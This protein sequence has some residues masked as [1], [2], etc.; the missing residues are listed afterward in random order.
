MDPR[1]ERLQ[2]ATR[3]LFLHDSAL[4]LGAMALGSLCA[5]RAAAD[6]ERPLATKAGAHPARAKHVIFV[7]LA[8]APPQLD[9]FD[10]KPKLN[11]LHGT[12]CPEEFIA[13]KRLAFIKGHP[14]LLGNQQGFVR[15]GQT[16]QWVSELLPCFGPLVDKVA[17]VRSMHTDQFNHAPADLFLHTGNAQFGAASIGSWLTWGLGSPNQNLPG[18]VVLVTGGSDPT[19][20][21][22][23]WGSGFLPSAYQGVR[24]RS[25]GEPLRQRSQGHGSGRAQAQPRRV[26]HVEREPA[27]PGRRP[28]DPRAHRSVRARL[29]HAALRARGDGPA[30]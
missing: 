11:A 28:G 9:L 1:D 4:G 20:G 19:G 16:G 6:Q 25:Q 23:T 8:G 22:S 14:T 17:M 12:L 26:A 30:P 2:R 15:R 13:G 29:P 10:Y 18:F 24:V 21:K 27:R 3:R 7:H 5:E